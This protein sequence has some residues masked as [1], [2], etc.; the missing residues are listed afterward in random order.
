MV[1]TRCRQ[2]RG[3]CFRG[4]HRARTQQHGPALCHALLCCLHHRGPALRA[5][6]VHD[7]PA[8]FTDHR[9]VGGHTQHLRAVVAAQL[10][11]VFRHRAAHAGQTQVL[12]EELW[13]GEAGDRLA[14]RGQGQAF[15]ELDE[16]VQAPLPS[17]VGQD[18]AS[19]FIDNLHL[20][21]LQHVVAVALVQQQGAQRL[22][23]ALLLHLH[24]VGQWHLPFIQPA[25]Q[26]VSAG[27]QQAHLALAQRDRVVITRCQA[28][29]QCQQRVQFTVVLG[30][31]FARQ[32]Q[33]RAGLVDQDA[34]GLVDDGEEQAPPGK[35]ITLGGLTV[36]QVIEHAILVDA[37][38]HV[39]GIGRA[40]L[41]RLR[42]PVHRSHAQAQALKQ[43]AHRIGVASSQVVIDSEDVHRHAAA[44]H[45]GRGQR[46]SQRLAFAGGHLHDA[47]AQQFARGQQLH[48]V[49][50]LAQA[51]PRRLA[52]QGHAVGQ[53][54]GARA[55]DTQAGLHHRDQ[56]VEAGVVQRGQAHRGGQHAAAPGQ[57]PGLHPLQRQH[58]RHAGQLCQPAVQPVGAGAGRHGALQ[59][60]AEICARRHGG[61]GSPRH[62]AATRRAGGCAAPIAR[63]AA[64]AAGRT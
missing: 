37:I 55:L 40:P 58:Q 57:A 53:G 60:G 32:D 43:R 20:V 62:R 31:T 30:T 4:L 1:Y 38:D 16:L 49:G 47:P 8:V 56:P 39:G 42:R 11:G 61:K 54:A 10:A 35:R 45:Q 6:G 14:R 33:R 2:Q 46:G 23:K 36:A 48:R 28:A 41:R 18:A 9:P 50:P 13:V 7:R 64:R 52:H 51:A 44:G 26:A 12:A 3:H 15:L 17:A 59:A 34:V 21:V 27:R 29:R 25:R 24:R 63:P 5:A 22:L 19:G